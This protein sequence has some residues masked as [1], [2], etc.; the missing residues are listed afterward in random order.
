M[1]V[2]VHELEMV[3]D[4]VLKAELELL[5]EF[6]KLL[7]EQAIKRVEGLFL[8]A[9]LGDNDGDLPLLTLGQFELDELLEGVY[10][11]DAG[12]D[13][14]EDAFSG[15]GGELVQNGLFL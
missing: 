8:G 2:V 9:A 13:G 7:C 12:H 1:G 14:H 11:V 4:A 15:V 3:P 6:D 5:V 10:E